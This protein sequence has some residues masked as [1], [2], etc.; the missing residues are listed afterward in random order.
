MN[1]LQNEILSVI[2]FIQAEKL[3]ARRE[4]A[5]VL[6]L[7]DMLYIRVSSICTK[8]GFDKA[9][10]DLEQSGIIKTGNTINDT[11]LVEVDCL[12]KDSEL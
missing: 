5:T 3:A 1:A 11:Y 6:L 8:E 10:S 12:E 7:Q 4:P 2:R 9:V